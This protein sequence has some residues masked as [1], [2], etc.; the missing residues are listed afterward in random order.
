MTS[1]P[2][3]AR[4][5]S[6]RSACSGSAPRR[7]G[8]TGC[9]CGTPA[10]RWPSSARLVGPAGRRAA[11]AGH[12][13]RAGRRRRAARRRGAG[14]GRRRRRSPGW[15]TRRPGGCRAGATS[16]TR[17]GGCCPRSAPTTWPPP[18][19]TAE[20]V[21]VEVLDGGDIAQLV[22]SLSAASTGDLL[23]LRPDQWR[24]PA[25]AQ[26]D[27]WVMD[28][29]RI[30]PP[31]PG[32]LPGPGAGGGAGGDPQPRGGG[33]ARA[34]PRRG[35]VPAG[36][37]GQLG[38]AGH[39][40]VREALRPPAGAPPA[41]A[42]RRADAALREPVGEGDGRPRAGRPAVRPRGP[43]TSGC[44][45]ASSPAAPRTS[46][47]PGP[48]GSASAR[49][50]AGWPSCSTSSGPTRGS[51]PASRRSGAAGSRR[52]A[53]T[54]RTRRARR[55]RCGCARGRRARRRRCSR[56]PARRR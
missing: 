51:R 8:S 56:S 29:M 13:V 48:S 50:D 11:R 45:S 16:S 24:L 21:T 41:V 43:A 15:S 36:D 44:C 28:L 12:P 2:L 47:S 26:I 52:A 9:C 30:G 7:R 31:V 40:A 34:D 55:A 39:R 10:A 20:P 42:G 33:R 4:R 18:A 17:S 14:A 6:P 3:T 19:P 25:G 1:L 49:Y 5:R 27:D 32:D 53:A 38:G 37:H 22:R 46:R 54:W 23:W 35:A